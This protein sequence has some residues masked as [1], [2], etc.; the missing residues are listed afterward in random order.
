MSRTEI[1]IIR[2]DFI[3]LNDRH[4]ECKNADGIP[5][6][7]QQFE[8]ELTALTKSDDKNLEN[9]STFLTILAPNLEVSVSHQQPMFDAMNALDE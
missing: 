8:M 3:Q 9:D 4:Y 6:K 5:R 7:L 1:R 2:N